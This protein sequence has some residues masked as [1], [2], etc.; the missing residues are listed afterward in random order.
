MNIIEAKL[1][2]FRKEVA[3]SGGSIGPLLKGQ[4]WIKIDACLTYSQLMA[5]AALIQ[6][7]NK[8]IK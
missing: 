5:L 4:Q 7:T 6:K 3:Q 8:G 2:E 1:D